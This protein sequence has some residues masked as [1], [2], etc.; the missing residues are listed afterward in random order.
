[1]N[2]VEI[3]G[4]IGAI[5]ITS[6]LFVIINLMVRK[7]VKKSQRPSEITTL[8]IM[9][10]IGTFASLYSLIT[11]KSTALRNPLILINY[12]LGIFWLIGIWKMKRWSAV[13]YILSALITQV[14]LLIQG[15][16]TIFS[17]LLLFPVL[18]LLYN[19]RRMS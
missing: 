16:L 18:I 19:Y 10:V 17:L 14:V 13:G 9:L 7:T 2:Q 4:L 3:K 1:M 5:L 8:S 12:I 11:L 6:L 15:S